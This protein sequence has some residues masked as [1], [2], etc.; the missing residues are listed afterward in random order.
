MACLHDQNRF[1][2]QDL[3]VPAN[4]FDRWVGINSPKATLAFVPPERT[5]LPSVSLSWGQ[6]F[7]TNDPRIGTGTQEGSLV[8]QAHAY[9]M[10][11]SKTVLKTDVRVTV[12]HVTQEA[13]LA[14]IDP[15]TGLQ[16]NEGPSV[17]RYVT[18]SARRHFSGG[19][20]Q[21]SVSKA[22]ARD[23]SSGLPVPEAPRLIV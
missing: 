21:A 4:S 7:F 10:V 15:D 18:G 17:N 2:N 13:S 1:D 9:Q 6:T 19:M 14:K 3:L 8:S 23:L 12:G 22:D 16:F 20:V 11:V 5:L